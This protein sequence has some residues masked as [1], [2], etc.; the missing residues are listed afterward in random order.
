MATNA[1]ATGGSSSVVN[2]NAIYNHDPDIQHRLF[3]KKPS[4]LSRFLRSFKVA[5]KAA[6]ILTVLS[7]IGL[8]A[9]L[10]FPLVT[11]GGG[12]SGFLTGATETYYTIQDGG[13]W[14]Y[15]RIT[16]QD[17]YAIPEF[18]P[19]AAG[20]VTVEN[21]ICW[22]SQP[23]AATID[24]YLHINNPTDA[25]VG[26]QLA[27]QTTSIPA[28]TAHFQDLALPTSQ[29]CATD[30]V[31]TNPVATGAPGTTINAQGHLITTPLKSGE[32]V[33]SKFIRDLSKGYVRNIRRYSEP[34]LN[35][36][37]YAAVAAGHLMNVKLDSINPV[38]CAPRFDESLLPSI[39][40][41]TPTSWE[42]S[43]SIVYASSFPVAGFKAS[44]TLDVAITKDVSQRSPILTSSWISD[45]RN[46][47]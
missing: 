28:D 42:C 10:T 38:Q 13:S 46:Q 47:T 32:R 11:Q 5:L 17:P 16:G 31:V 2:V 30:V 25:A 33:V 19:Y 39:S 23:G 3:P 8:Y 44:G 45:L 35:S 7:L 37:F 14:L 36:E 29:G 12:A 27:G 26:L 9:F 41:P 34:N 40:F 15:G 22:E 20:S 43:Y 1:A 6:A 4:F 24:G 18:Q 21:M